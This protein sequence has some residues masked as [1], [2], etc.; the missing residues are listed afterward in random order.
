MFKQI[1]TYEYDMELTQEIFQQ[2]NKDEK[3][4]WEEK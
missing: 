4:K 3:I 1:I 2:K